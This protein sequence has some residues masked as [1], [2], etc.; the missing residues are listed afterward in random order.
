MTARRHRRLHRV[1]QGDQL[2]QAARLGL[3][4]Q[5]VRVLPQHRLHCGLGPQGHGHRRQGGLRHHI[6]QRVGGKAIVQ[7]IGGILKPLGGGWCLHDDGDQLHAV[8]LGRT[9][10]A[11]Q[12]T[13]C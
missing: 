4:Q 3:F 7:Q 11:V 1:R 9:G 2:L 8:P 6:L 12:R 13:V 10:E 5:E